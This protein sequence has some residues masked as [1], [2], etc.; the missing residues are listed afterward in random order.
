MGTV[1]RHGGGEASLGLH[2]NGPCPRWGAPGASPHP[3]PAPGGV[4]TFTPIMG[5]SLTFSLR[6]ALSSKGG[7][8][9]RVETCRFLCGKANPVLTPRARRETLGET[10]GKV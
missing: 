7:R 10:K 8:L 4:F 6:G 3:G 9:E 1:P 2:C 5:R